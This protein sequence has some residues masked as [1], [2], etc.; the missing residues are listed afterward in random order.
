MAECLTVA[1][2]K[3]RLTPALKQYVDTTR[4]FKF[5][6]YLETC[7]E[8][9]R[10]QPRGTSCFKKARNSVTTQGG[11]T[12]NSPYPL[13][14]ALKCFGCKKM[15]H[16]ASE[17]RSRPQREAQ[18]STI[19]SAVTPRV[20]GKRSEAK[21]VTCFRCHQNKHK[22]PACPS[23]PKGNKRVNLPS[24]KLLYLQ[25]NEFLDRLDVTRCP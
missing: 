2:T 13:K 24:D 15:G 6:E 18:M 23:R 5:Q 16:V 11:R 21:E 22:S 9:E 25:P 19:Q 10:N 20:A 8:W 14:S 3:D 1:L 7:E 4:K 17:C 12:M